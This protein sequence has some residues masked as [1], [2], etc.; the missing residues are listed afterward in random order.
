MRY[1]YLKYSPQNASKVYTQKNTS[2]ATKLKILVYDG[3]AKMSGSEA[4]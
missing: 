3:I 1:L 2:C 4:A